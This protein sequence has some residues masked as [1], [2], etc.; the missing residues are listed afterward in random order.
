M[1]GE[2]TRISNKFLYSNE[3]NSLYAF[4]KEEN[5]W[6][7]LKVTLPEHQLYFEGDAFY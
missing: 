1:E 7:V 2:F 4:S 6:L 3:I 5:I